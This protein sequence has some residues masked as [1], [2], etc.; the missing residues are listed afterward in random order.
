MSATLLTPKT[1][2]PLGEFL[3]QNEKKLLPQCRNGTLK[4]SHCDSCLNVC[5]VYRK[6]ELYD[7]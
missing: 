2:L 6:S 1:P 5:M 7:M 4:H 3:A